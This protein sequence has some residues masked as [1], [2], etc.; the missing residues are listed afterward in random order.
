MRR[1]IIIA[2]S[3]VAGGADLATGL[4]LICTPEWTLAR[5]GVPYPP[6]LVFLRFVGV[7]VACVGASYWFGLIAWWLS[8]CSCR[9]RF[10]WE[11]T[12]LFRVAVGFFVAAQ[13]LAGHLPW[14]WYSVPAVDWTWALVQ[15]IGLRVGFHRGVRP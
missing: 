9:L 8:G 6:E 7:F 14:Q 11:L 12:I 5:M 2:L 3:L 1:G 10:V 4:L 13:I 15:G